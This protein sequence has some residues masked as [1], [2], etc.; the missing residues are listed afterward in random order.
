MSKSVSVYDLQLIPELAH[1]SIFDFLNPQNDATVNPF[2]Y[3]MGVDVER[4]LEYTCSYHRTLSKQAKV[5]Y[6]ITGEMRSDKEFLLS[7]WC[8]SED[9]LIAAG[10]VDISLARELGAMMNAQISYDNTDELEEAEVGEYLQDQE[11]IDRIE[12]EMEVMEQMLKHVRGE[13]K[14]RDGSFKKPK[15][16]HS[17]EPYEKV[18]RKKKNRSTLKHRELKRQEV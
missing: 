15:D 4:G 9:R 8:S 1:F 5:G 16:Y 10:R 18:R 12:D 6:V 11:D 13:Q 7:P 14:K 3:E 2:L 17:E